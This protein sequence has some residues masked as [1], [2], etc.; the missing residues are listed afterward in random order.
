MTATSAASAWAV[1][2][3]LNGPADR[4]LIEHWNGAAWKVVPS[5]SPG[6]VANSLQAVAATAAGNAWAVGWYLNGTG[7]RRTLAEHWNGRSWKV[8]PSPSAGTG[9]NFLWSV[10]ATSATNAWMVGNLAAGTGFQTL[11]EHWN[12]S[13][14]RRVATPSPGG[15]GA[16]NILSGV[17]GT[18]C[19]NAW[20][21]GDYSNGT[22][23]SALAVH[24]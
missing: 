19:G 22:G 23:N 5:P 18:D 9:D 4:T 7:S 24:C 2:Y 6:T 8:V 12:G 21:V 10:D 16:N 17:A 1:G 3:N 20:A 14:W 15:A 11:L 13:T